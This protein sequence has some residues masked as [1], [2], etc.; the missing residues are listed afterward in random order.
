MFHA[1][2]TSF[3]VAKTCDLASERGVKVALS[4][5]GLPTPPQKINNQKA[6]P[7]K[8]SSNFPQHPQPH[9]LDNSHMPK[10]PMST[11]ASE[12][13]NWIRNFVFSGHR[14]YRCYPF[15]GHGRH[16][17]AVAGGHGYFG[18]KYP[19]GGVF[20]GNATSLSRPGHL[21]FAGDNGIVGHDPENHRVL[22][23]ELSCRQATC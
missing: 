15:V 2:R 14:D 19:N 10:S 22:I 21:L 4:L 12:N 20:W 7:A 1:V 23:C 16:D 11:T 6:P 13:G 8:N 9:A 18:K 5:A 3:E 17:G